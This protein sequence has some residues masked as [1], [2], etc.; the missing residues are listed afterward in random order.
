MVDKLW[1]DDT[2]IIWAV[3]IVSSGRVSGSVVSWVIVQL[4]SVELM[5]TLLQN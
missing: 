5:C 2:P 3:Y 4:S 1:G